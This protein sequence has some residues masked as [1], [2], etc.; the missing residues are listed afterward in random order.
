VVL[1]L[2]CASSA[3]AESAGTD[4]ASAAALFADAKAMMDKGNYTEACPKLAKSE[5]LDPQVGTM[6][7]LAA[8]YESLGDSASSCAWWRAVATAAARKSQSDR[9]TYARE[10]AQTTCGPAAPAT[11]AG[12]ATEPTP[13]NPAPPRPAR[14]D[15]SS[16]RLS[17]PPPA[18]PA[19]RRGNL[20]TAAWVLGAGGVAS[21]GVAA[22]FG[23]AAWV[24]ADAS[25]EGRR[26]TP[27]NVCN[28]LGRQ[29][30]NRAVFDAT[31]ADVGIA[32]GAA[33]VTAGI[34]MWILDRPKRAPLPTGI[35]VQPSVALESWSVTVGET[36]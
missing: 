22:G 5:A 27:N 16:S 26:C 34:V 8:C 24:N 23:A 30:R 29:E 15:A 21:L 14:D 33:A 35:Y 28:E 17:V 11:S 12:T 10:Q 13:E 2:S 20:T 3:A 6:L 18:P 32:V 9:E 31:V 25:R 4:G 36:W 7:N 1:A 19:P